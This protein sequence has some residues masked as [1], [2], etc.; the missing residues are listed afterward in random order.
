[1]IADK[2][3]REHIKHLLTQAGVDREHSP[4]VFGKVENQMMQLAHA[5]AAAK[6]SNKDAIYA[7]REAEIFRSLA[8]EKEQ[9]AEMIMMGGT[10]TRGVM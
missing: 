4:D 3:L 2:K 10:A 5:F 7:E 1:M 9:T 6:E 8:K